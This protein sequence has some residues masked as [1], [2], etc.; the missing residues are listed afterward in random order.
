MSRAA[1]HPTAA[2]ASAL[3]LAALVAGGLCASPWIAAAQ[4]GQSSSGPRQ[5]ARLRG[6]TLEQAL[7]VLRERGV[8]LVF[9]SALVRPEMT[10]NVE[11]TAT[12]PRRLLAQLL[13][14]H[15][16]R[17][18]DGEGGSTVV[19]PRR[20]TTTR[21]TAGADAVRGEVRSLFDGSPI[22]GAV[23][24][25]ARAGPDPAVEAANAPS[26]VL[27]AADGRFVLTGLAPGRWTVRVH[28]PAYSPAAPA[29]VGLPEHLETGA[30]VLR[31]ALRPEPFLHDEIVVA[32]SR[33]TLLRAD[34][35]GPLSLSRS[36]VESLPH[37]GGDVFRALTL[38]PGTAANDNTAQLSIHGG[39]RDELLIALDGQELYRAF[40]LRDFDDALSVVPADTLDGVSLTTGAF[41]A[42]HGDRMGGVLDLTTASPSRRVVRLRM[43]V[44]NAQLSAGG[45]LG[46][47]RGSWL[48]SLRRGSIDLT[49]RI[50]GS[51]DP[52][53]WDV[54]GKLE[55][56]FGD[57]HSL[58]AQ[59]LHAGDALELD[60]IE[61]D[62]VKRFDTEYD[63]AYLWLVHDVLVGDRT[64][65]QTR[66]AS[67][68]FER[69]RRGFESEEEQ[70]WE[71]LDRRE[72][73]VSELE[74]RW[75]FEAGSRAST[76]WGVALRRF[77]TEY[78]Y[79][80]S[81]EA[82]QLP[83]SPYFEPR[84]ELR[85][86]LGEESDEHAGAWLS[87]RLSPLASLTLELGGR[88]DR[89]TL[90]D[91]ELWSPRLNLAWRPGESSVVR[92]G[93]GHFF[94]SQRSYELGVADGESSFA[95]AE[96]AEHA[97]L[98]YE[99]Q[100]S[101]R[102][103]AG[104]E[105]LR[106]EAYRRSIRDPRDGFEN[107]YEPINT[108]PEIEPDRVRVSP[109][110]SRAEV[111]ELTLRGAIGARATWWLAYGLQRAED[112]VAS[113]WVPRPLDQPHTLNVVLG[114]RLGE[115]WQLDLAWRFHTGWPTTPVTA[116]PGAPPS[117][118]NGE[119]GDGEGDP[120]SQPEL[121]VGRLNSDRLPDYHRLDLRLSRTWTLRTSRLR[122]FL[123]VQ[124]AYDRENLAGFDL[125]IDDDSGVL[126]KIPERWTG[127]FP[128][129]G[130]TWEF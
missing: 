7:L 123:D 37:L 94:Q 74:S 15:G 56:S 44:L 75:S 22:A 87:Q 39:R 25:A 23:V 125:S 21:R 6:L 126:E 72:T 63:G 129:V 78:D 105:A 59:A 28:H 107:L 18:V 93:W 127:I 77:D 53:F 117:D 83:P 30:A 13:A 70:T 17:A 57:R 128:S 66:V 109:E 85:R 47:D 60:E 16:L 11:P 20:A 5:T 46:G 24:Q 92:F 65:V 116:L 73:T 32:A 52:S 80:S 115:A 62:E 96:R 40:H 98:G 121:L 101:D 81:A 111:A 99:R 42:P 103:R 84:A 26:P 1:C 113:D 68:S 89:H 102:P 76:G 130:I 112:R 79:A 10:V 38:M 49:S 45:A 14:P 29:E 33:S 43:S 97:V 120:S 31:I 61:D 27:T 12:E 8:D 64:L 118:E 50:F 82:A 2:A 4:A 69:D 90:T 86:F 104:L 119:G 41:G 100:L 110:R 67:S 106:V 36:E 108:F 58:R 71:V 48:T 34:P 55:R 95:P 51:E 91:D 3:G 124:N 54:S 122:F 35:A 114:R 19:V 88:F 9:S